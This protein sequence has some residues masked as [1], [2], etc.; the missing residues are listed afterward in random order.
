M[1]TSWF[2]KT[3]CSICSYSSVIFDLKGRPGGNAAHRLSSN[4]AVYR[5]IPQASGVGL[6]SRSVILGSVQLI[7]KH[8]DQGTMCKH[9]T[10]TWGN[11]NSG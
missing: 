5:L 11:M 10:H 7:Q 6:K 2:L 8:L 4:K 3:A 9:I 1:I